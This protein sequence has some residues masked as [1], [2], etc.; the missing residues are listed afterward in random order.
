MI[1]HAKILTEL[2][3]A[4]MGL[5]VTI[6][7]RGVRLRRDVDRSLLTVDPG[8]HQAALDAIASVELAHVPGTETPATRGALPHLGRLTS[9][10]VAIGLEGVGFRLPETWPG[11]LTVL[12][13]KA[14]AAVTDRPASVAGQIQDVID[15]HAGPTA[16]E[17]AAEAAAKAIAEVPQG[18]LLEALMNQLPGLRAELGL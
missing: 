15:Q 13:V 12:H 2:R 3:A 11:T 6:D 1:D 7:D 17:L 4:G 10:L 8:T 18:V 16:Q 14:S 5:P 9:E